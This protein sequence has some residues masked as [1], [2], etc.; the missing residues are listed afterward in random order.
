MLK[1]H[2]GDLHA[3]GW[4]EGPWWPQ[5][6]PLW[7]EWGFI[8]L[9]YAYEF[10]IYWEAFEV[11]ESSSRDSFRHRKRLSKQ[12]KV[13]SS[14]FWSC[15]NKFREQNFAKRILIFLAKREKICSISFSAKVSKEKRTLMD[16]PD[17]VW[18]F[19]PLFL[20]LSVCLYLCFFLS[21]CLYLA[22]CLPL[23]AFLSFCWSLY[24]FPFLRKSSSK[25]GN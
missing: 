18:S 2:D 11:Q 5:K 21:R 19:R 3:V 13:H 16:A 22:F 9:L 10:I 15:K 12:G 17:W 4:G 20:R 25:W 14:K 8:S 7:W 6:K 23:Y 24:P 1:L